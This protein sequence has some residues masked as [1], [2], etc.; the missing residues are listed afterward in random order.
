[1][2]T[3]VKK[4][5]S[6]FEIALLLTGTIEL[7]PDIMAKNGLVN[8]PPTLEVGQV[9]E[10]NFTPTTNVQKTA[11]EAQQNTPIATATTEGLPAGISYWPIQVDFV[12]T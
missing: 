2:K 10:Y 4:N 6:I 9:I 12:V 1:M 11:I 3:I 8:Y 7:V 5:Q